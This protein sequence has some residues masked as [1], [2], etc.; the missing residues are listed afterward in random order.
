M[1][2]EFLYNLPPDDTYWNNKN[3]F[4]KA[5]FMKITKDIIT[6]LKIGNHPIDLQNSIENYKNQTKTM[7]E[8]LEN[9]LKILPIHLSS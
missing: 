7:A 1:I 9:Y 4:T 2:F 8:W 6:T 3:R 5:V